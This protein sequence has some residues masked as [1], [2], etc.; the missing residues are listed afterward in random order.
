MS[1][2][3]A[4][5]REGGVL[6]RFFV[7][8]KGFHI[9]SFAF[10]ILYFLCFFGPRREIEGCELWGL[11]VMEYMWCIRL[12][13]VFTFSLDVI[14]ITGFCHALAQHCEFHQFFYRTSLESN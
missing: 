4:K 10:F 11:Y 13:L 14:L 6:Y 8:R 3:G 7:V 5:R 12:H 1:E 2:L 9:C